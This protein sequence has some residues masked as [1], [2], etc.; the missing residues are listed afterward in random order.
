M[1]SFSFLSIPDRL[2][3][4]ED[5]F[6]LFGKQLVAK[7]RVALPCVVQSFDA[8]KQTV[9]VLPSVSEKVI[10][11]VGGVP[12]AEDMPWTKPLVDIPVVFPRAGNFVLTMPVAAGDECLVVFAD[13]CI[14]GWWQSGG[15]GNAQL[16][17][18][19]HDLSD[20]FALIGPWSQPKVIPSYSTA[21]AELRTLDGTTK[22][23]LLAGGGVKI[24]GAVETS[25]TMTVDTDLKVEG[26][27]GFY[28]TSPATK[29][30][31]TGSKSANA[32][33]ASLLT[34]LAGI[35]LLTDSTT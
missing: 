13:Y 29:P 17:K 5:Q 14:D 32:A 18:R 7:M 11:N 9:T 8:T 25:S 31:V 33:L 24:T 12:V 22:I 2:G 35:G 10:M 16:D 26:K 34:A 21:N 23:T 30:V 20:G 27:I 4:T 15:T 19:R 6:R 28:N 1:S 3:L